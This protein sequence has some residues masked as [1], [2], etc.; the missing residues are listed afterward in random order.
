MADLLQWLSNAWAVTSVWELIAVALAIAY[1]LFA[2]K[3]N[4]LCWPAALIST[5]IYTWLFFSVTLVM[6]S[7]LQ[8]YYMACLLYTSDAADD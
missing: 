3:E 1:L 8:V 2:M 7:L 4:I 5:A 6:E